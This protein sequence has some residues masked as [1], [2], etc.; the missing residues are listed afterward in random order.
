MADTQHESALGILP[1]D[2]I[3][4]F[5]LHPDGNIASQLEA[6]SAPNRDGR[7]GER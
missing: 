3:P 2:R 7:F 6:E 1:I 4:A 5:T